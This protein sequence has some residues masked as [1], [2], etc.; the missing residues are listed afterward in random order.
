MSNENGKSKKKWLLPLILV[1]ALAAGGA[2]IYA[3]TRGGNNGGETEPVSE[4]AAESTPAQTQT[5]A[6]NPTEPAATEPTTPSETEPEKTAADILR[7]RLMADG[8]DVIELTEDIEVSGETLTVN[9]TKTLSGSGKILAKGMSDDYIITISEGA[10]LTIDGP[11]IDGSGKAKNGIL[12]SKDARL[13]FESGELTQL[14]K[15]GIRVAGEALVKAK[16]SQ[17]GTNWIYLQSGGQAELEEAEF[18]NC[19]D[20]G[21]QVLSNTR[22][23]VRGG[24]FSGSSGTILYNRGVTEIENAVFSDSELYTVSNGGTMTMKNTELSGAKSQGLVYNYPDCTLEMSDCRL[25]DS[26]NYIFYNSGKA[27]LDNVTMESCESHAVYNEGNTA[28]LTVTNATLD[29]IGSTAFFNKADSSMTLE[30]I[31]IIANGNHALYNRAG[32]MVA[33]DITSTASPKTIVCNDSATDTDLRY[34]TLELDGFA[35]SGGE[36]YGISSYGGLLTVKNG[37][38]DV[39]GSYGLYIKDG[40]AV[41]ENVDLKGTSDPEGRAVVQIGIT[42][43]ENAVVT[44]TNVNITGGARGIGNHGTLTYN[45][46]TISG[47]RN[48]GQI[49]YGGGIYNFNKLTLNG[50]TISG[51]ESMNTGGGIYNAGTMVMNGGTVTNNKAAASGGGIANKA[52]CYLT[53]N[54]GTISKNYAPNYGGGI[55]NKGKV[56]M[57]GGTVSGNS[58]GKIGGGVHSARYFH[59]INGTITGNTAG[60]Q[61]GGVYNTA[62]GTAVLSGGVISNNK[63]SSEKGGGGVYNTGKMT[64]EKT[65]KLKNNQAASIGGAILNSSTSTGAWGVLTVTGGVFEGNSSVSSGGAIYSSATLVLSGA[66]FTDNKAGNN[67]GAVYAASDSEFTISGGSFD[68]NKAGNYGGTLYLV[69]KGEVSNIQVTNS[70]CEGGNGGAVY[71]TSAADVTMKNSSITNSSAPEKGHAIYLYKGVLTLENCTVTTA[72]SGAALYNNGGTVTLGGKDTVSVYTENAIQLKNDF[73]TDSDLTVLLD[74]YTDGKEVLSGNETVVA[75]VYEKAVTL[76]DLPEGIKLDSDGRLEDSNAGVEAVLYDAAGTE[77]ARGSFM[78]MMN[79]AEADQTVE[80]IADA[81]LTGKLTVEK[82]LTI[83][84]DGTPRAILVSSTERAFQTENEAVLRL[85]GRGGLTVRAADGMTFQTVAIYVIRGVLEAEGPVTISGFNCDN[86]AKNNTNGAAVYVASSGSIKLNGTTI[87]GNTAAANGAAIYIYG[88]TAELTDVT[89]SGN[90]AGKGDDIY[91]SNN[92]SVTIKGGSFTSGAVSD[93]SIYVSAGTLSFDGKTQASVYTGGA[94]ALADGFDSSSLLNIYLDA[95]TDGRVVLSGS[96]AVVK[97]AVNG[98][99]AQMPA[100]PTGVT[101][102]EDGKLKEAP[103]TS[104]EAILYDASGKKAD[105]GRFTAMVNAAENGWTIE[106]VDDVE[107]T[108]TVR[109]NKSLTIRDDGTP[110]AFL[111]GDAAARGLEFY[112]D[113]GIEESAYPTITLA[114]SEAGGLTVRAKNAE[115]EFNYVAI[116]V[117]RAKL[118]TSGK[119]TVTDYRTNN[120]VTNNKNGG[121][122]NIASSGTLEADGLTVTNITAAAKG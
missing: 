66:S 39:C 70:S 85:E 104:P 117:I 73:S 99:A 36:G 54:G 111:I 100:L 107:L 115:T 75:A 22:L 69:T 97:A 2:G 71:I 57:F 13:D 46:G 34:G 23:S 74:S 120:T 116:Y 109:I 49:G 43:F 53:I 62:E 93:T 98:G 4:S 64:V 68:G 122:F 52:E 77:L 37:T 48:F 31:N 114:G 67:G 28:D 58:C 44:M 65:V 51:N 21:L 86:T 1:L 12:V 14:D 84:D 88:G 17:V 50:G 119:V 78:A 26:Q 76:P 90:T 10:S 24:S 110:R 92:G 82:N 118:V 27:V 5:P 32:R 96:A 112:G 106:L 101:L 81:V 60:A 33:K 61:G 20:F 38:V 35:I 94:I 91:L 45:S 47:N 15:L 30:H 9:G 19:G 11:V 16:I 83:R 7:E 108:S 113:S 79:R 42:D 87:S 63:S 105:E 102:E 59:L 41:I 3:L 55:Y 40:E 95:Y 6:G 29:K 72:E 121:A 103:L 89:L 56:D 80:L 18:E 25:H 8:E